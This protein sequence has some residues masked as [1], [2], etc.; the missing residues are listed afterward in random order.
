MAKAPTIKPAIQTR[1]TMIAAIIFR[2]M[3]STISFRRSNS[4]KPLPNF[5]KIFIFIN[6]LIVKL[7]MGHIE[8]LLALNAI[9]CHMTFKRRVNEVISFLSSYSSLI[10]IT[11]PFP[12]RQSPIVLTE[13]GIDSSTK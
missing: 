9:K 11:P 6:D 2:L 12:K 7:Q 4:A 8:T 10:F 13:R 5:G 3:Y 1:I